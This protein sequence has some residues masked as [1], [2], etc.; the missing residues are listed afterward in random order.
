MSGLQV[1]SMLA[2]LPS[3]R[4]A[5][6]RHLWSTSCRREAAVNAGS[7][8]SHAMHGFPMLCNQQHQWLLRVRPWHT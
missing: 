3:P 5:G 6:T 2:Y 8:G 1:T 4:L 7:S